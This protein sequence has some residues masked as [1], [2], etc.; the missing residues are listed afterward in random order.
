MK[1]LHTHRGP[2]PGHVVRRSSVYGDFINLYQNKE[3]EENMVLEYPMR[4]Y[5]NKKPWDGGGVSRDALSQF[6]DE[7]YTA[8]FDGGNLL[9][10]V[11][12]PQS[13]LSVFPV[14]GRT[15]SWISSNRSS[16][17][18]HSISVSSWYVAGPL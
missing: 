1:S 4:I 5:E 17:C 12:T 8:L 3:E 13:D 11:I 15:L 6:W 7:A 18:T 16:P 2:I 10:P 9:I 14:L